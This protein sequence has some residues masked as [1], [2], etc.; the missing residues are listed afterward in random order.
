MWDLVE[1][2]TRSAGSCSAMTVLV[3]TICF[4]HILSTSLRNRSRG[5]GTPFAVRAID[6]NPLGGR[7]SRVRRRKRTWF[8]PLLILNMLRTFRFRLS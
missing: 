4:F 7:R 2:L 5:R 6:P 1:V 8:R 3:G